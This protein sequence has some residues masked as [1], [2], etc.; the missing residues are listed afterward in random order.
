[1]VQSFEA[2]EL[3]KRWGIKPVTIKSGDLKGGL[4]PFEELDPEQVKILQSMVSSFNEHFQKLVQDRRGLSNE[5]MDVVSDGRVFSGG[6][7]LQAGLIDEIGAEDEILAY[8]GKEKSIQ[9]LEIRDFENK[10]E[11][12]KFIEKI[13]GGA[14]KD[15]FYENAISSLNFQ[16]ITAM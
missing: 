4:S 3:V 1:M 2:S 15:F 16:K 7:A 5:Q 8:L 6:Q 11:E 14:L 13:I 10:T 9:N 12:E